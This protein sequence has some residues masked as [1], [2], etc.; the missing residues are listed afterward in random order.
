MELGEAQRLLAEVVAADRPAADRDQLR[1]AVADLARLRGFLDR[2]ATAL[3]SRLAAVSAMPEQDL[4]KAARTSACDAEQL[5]ARAKLVDA[6]PPLGDA[7]AAGTVSGGHVDVFERGWRSLE[8]DL[9]PQL[10]GAAAQLVAV[11][12]RSTPEEF[13]R[14]VKAEVRRLRRDDGQARLEQQQRAPARRRDS[15]RASPTRGRRCSPTAPRPAA[16][17]RARGRAGPGRSRAGPSLVSAYV[18]RRQ[19]PS[20]V[21]S[22]RKSAVGVVVAQR[23]STSPT[24]RS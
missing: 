7:L 22:Q 3:A 10:T 4:A 18:T 17:R 8:P 20:G 16:H 12:E 1:S 5:L 2:C 14:A 24:L 21:R 6:T 19:L 11:A 13:D 23:A 15:N 9:R